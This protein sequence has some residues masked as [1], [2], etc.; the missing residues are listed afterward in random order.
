MTMTSSP[1]RPGRR[2]TAAVVTVLALAAGL[3]GCADDGTEESATDPSA[4]PTDTGSQS[5]SPTATPSESPTQTSPPADSGEGA[6]AIIAATGS[7]G[8][9]E[10][11]LVSATEGGGSV[12]TLS[13]TLDSDQAVADFTAQ[14]NADL[15]ATLQTAATELTSQVAPGSTAYGATAAI[16]C[17]APRSVAVDAGEAG[18]EVVAALPKST[19][20]CLAPMTYVVLFAVPDA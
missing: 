3:A 5:P 4:V 7:A 6:R 15:A 19:V 13:W 17:E 1:R 14:F 12:S 16:G 9:T 20:Q 8:A 2:S 10:A 18:F 11:T